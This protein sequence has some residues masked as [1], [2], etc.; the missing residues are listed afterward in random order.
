MDYCIKESCPYKNPQQDSV[1]IDLIRNLNEHK[2]KDPYYTMTNEDE[3]ST[4]NIEK[5]FRPNANDPESINI[6][7]PIN[8]IKKL[9]FKAIKKTTGRRSKNVKYK[10]PYSKHNKFHEDNLRQKIKVHFLDLLRKYIN[11]EYKKYFK[12]NFPN[13]KFEK[14]L[15]MVERDD[16]ESTT[17]ENEIDLLS[18]KICEYFSKKPS[19]RCKKHSEDYNII[20]I[21][22]IMEKR[23][24]KNLFDLF[25][26]TIEEAFGTYILENENK[27]PEFNFEIDL[28][29]IKK[30]D[31]I[32]IG[33]KELEE[34]KE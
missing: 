10:N 16:K 14:L 18:S 32:I 8:K 12:L 21:K 13:E 22:K 28:E 25:N 24:P 17:N 30:E 4:E 31:E 5:I 11:L 7:I 3:I 27:I 33:D 2:R 9:T 29:E 1:E 19:N 20:N 26:E 34:K 6:I 23:Q 15:L